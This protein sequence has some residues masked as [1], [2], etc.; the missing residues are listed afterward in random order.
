MHI[1]Y[2]Y[3]YNA[4]FDL[5]AKSCESVCIVISV[6]VRQVFFGVTKTL[7]L[8]LRHSECDKCQSLYEGMSWAVPTGTAS[9]DLN[10]ISKSQQFEIAAKIQDIF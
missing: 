8:F 6:N 10:H 3:K 7:T 5:C 2:N 9:S 4:V 1:I